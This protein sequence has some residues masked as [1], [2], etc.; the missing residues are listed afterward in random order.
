MKQVVSI[1]LGASRDDYEFST[2]FLGKDIHITRIGTDGNLDRAATLLLE[3][4][5]KVDAIGLGSVKFPYKVGPKFLTERVTRKIGNL[6]ARLK[7]PVTTGDS[8][9][10]VAFEWSMR[11][12]QFEFPDI[13]S[14]AWVFYFSGLMNYNLAKI[15]GEYTDNMMFADPVLEHGIPKLLNTMEDVEKYAKGIHGILKWVPTKTL[16]S[17]SIPVHYWNSH[18]IKKALQKAFMVMVPYHGFYDYLSGTTYEELGGKVVITST[19]YKDR[20]KFLAERGVSMIIDNTPK[21]LEHI[22][23]VNVLEALIIAALEKPKEKIKSDELLEIIS[24]L[25]MEPRVLFPSGKTWRKNR[26]AFVIHPLSQEDFKKEKMIEKFTT[27]PGFTDT[28]EKVMAYSPPFLYTKITG[29]K[30]PTGTETEGWLISVGGTPKQMLAHSPEF[31]YKRLLQAARMAKKLGAQIMGLGAFTKVVGDAGLT[32]SRR[33]D[34]PI[35]TG[36]SYSASAALWAAADAVRRMGLMPPAETG[37]RVPAKTMVIGATGAI[38]SVCS[39]LLALA[40]DEL[41]LAGR[42]TAKLLALKD[43][44]HREAPDV[45]I[46]L[47]TNPDKYLADMDVIVTTTSGAGKKVLDITMVKPGCVI[48]DVARPLDLKPDDVKK[49]PDVLVIESG[50]ILLP[51]DAEMK[52]IGLPPK[53]VYACLA[54][55]IVLALEGKFE[56]FTVGRDIEWQKVKEIYKLGLKHGMRLAAISGVNGVFTDDDIARVRK[57]AIKE[58]KKLGLEI[59]AHLDDTSSP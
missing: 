50:E 8:L 16:T 4:D 46:H 3:Y 32:V 48:T 41:Y 29:V 25:K 39:R 17:S 43:S 7:T 59:P 15:I 53:V 22:V 47:T 26:F 27:I 28:L 45:T 14:N 52:T 12:L 40:F 54:E 35:T 19:L 49:R 38:G 1:S 6:G 5:G 18:I 51:G 55:T 57:L 10:N 42:N 23:G 30:S 33:A 20:E 58:R 34:L 13:F 56:V 44:I 31:T 24:E 37:Q 11:H 9:R 36:N 21:I 2:K